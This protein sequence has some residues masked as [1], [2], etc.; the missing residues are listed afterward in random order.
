V[1]TKLA[2]KKPKLLRS[3]PLRKSLIVSGVDPSDIDG[4]T[5]ED[6]YVSYRR[7]ELV[8]IDYKDDDDLSEDIQWRL[9]LAR[10]LALLK[11]REVTEKKRA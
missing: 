5:D 7:P 11:Y 2:I 10:Q 8:K 9:F 6:I 4:I 3:N 1:P